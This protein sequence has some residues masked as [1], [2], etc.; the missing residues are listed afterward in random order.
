MKLLL[1]ATVL[2]AAAYAQAD[3][4]VEMIDGT[5]VKGDIASISQDEVK[6]TADSKERTIARADVAQITLGDADNLMLKTGK[7]VVLSSCGDIMSAT[8][9]TASQSGFDFTSDMCGQTQLPIGNA[10]GLFMES[11]QFSP[12]QLQ[13]KCKDFW[14]RKAS[15]DVL[16]A[17]SKPK[18]K[19]KEPT[20]GSA[21][22]ALKA[23]DAKTVTFR[24]DDRDNQ[25]ERVNVLALRCAASDTKYPVAVGQIIAKDGTTISFSS[26]AVTKGTV[27]IDSLALGKKSFPLTAVAAMHFVSDKLVSL[28]DLKPSKV[29]E[30]PYSG[31]LLFKYCVNTSARGTAIILGGKTYATGLGL[32]SRCEL[33]YDLDGK[34]T[35]FVTTAGIDDAVKTLGLGEADLT[36]TADGKQLGEVLRLTGKDE[37]PTEIKL[38]VTK[39]KTLIIRVDF[40]KDKVG[41][42]D[43][44]DL[45]NARLI[46]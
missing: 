11:A 32:H 21:E 18:E 33:T 6:I 1:A 28:G 19:D 4:C 39:A 46:K 45:A 9:L 40:A 26:L 43:D 15:E 3:T 29:Q 12:R 20:P 41:V 34:F 37:H 13:E 25:A 10:W 17:M 44:V 36:I 8:N 31:P 23:I 14:P 24:V 30:Q 2:F 7:T 35:K 22:G 27:A 42:G 16:V 38:D 5:S